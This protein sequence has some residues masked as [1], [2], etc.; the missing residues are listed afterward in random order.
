MRSGI[1]VALVVS[2]ERET[3]G[4]VAGT[5]KLGRLTS[6]YFVGLVVMVY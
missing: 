6:N 4:W 1:A 3:F 5:Q 2:E